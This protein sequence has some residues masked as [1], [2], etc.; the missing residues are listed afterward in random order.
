MRCD[1]RGE[2][3]P[4]TAILEA[5]GSTSVG[6]QNSQLDHSAKKK[7]AH[8][9]RGENH[10][11]ELT[12]ATRIAVP[13]STPDIVLADP[14]FE[15]PEETFG[16][17]GRKVYRY[18]HW[19]R[20]MRFVGMP[21][22]AHSFYLTSNKV[23]RGEDI[24][25]VPPPVR[26]PRPPDMLEADGARYIGRWSRNWVPDDGRYRRRVAAARA[27]GEA[28]PYEGQVETFQGIR[29]DILHDLEHVG[30]ERIGADGG[31]HPEDWEASNGVPVSVFADGTAFAARV[32]G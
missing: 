12:V 9:A 26:A 18:R 28:S 14:P 11:I 1:F 21:E 27:E 8:R 4:L 6:T 17:R 13:G 32:V 29:E 15:V 2:V 20:I 30:P 23:A 22:L 19:C 25:L 5:K 24:P 3:G 31:A 16:P 10:D 7:A